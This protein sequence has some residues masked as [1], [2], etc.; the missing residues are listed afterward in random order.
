MAATLSHAD[1]S[2]ASFYRFAVACVTGFPD[3]INF[4]SLPIGHQMLTEYIWSMHDSQRNEGRDDA[5]ERE[6]LA[7]AARE[8]ILELSRAQKW[9]VGPA[10]AVREKLYGAVRPR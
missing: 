1:R 3:G 6:Y 5:A 8:R 7:K 9:Y 4:L 2:C 10:P